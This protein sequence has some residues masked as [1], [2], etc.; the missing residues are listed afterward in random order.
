MLDKQ[1]LTRLLPIHY[2]RC[3]LN[4]YE[5]KLYG[6]SPLFATNIAVE[7]PG[8]IQVGDDVFAVEIEK[9]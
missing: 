4:K 5:K 9:Q 2:F 6:Q 1:L 7:H 8:E 3:T